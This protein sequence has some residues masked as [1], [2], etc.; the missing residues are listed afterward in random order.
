MFDKRLMVFLAASVGGG[1]AIGFFTLPGEWYARLE[2]P[3]F[4][5]PNWIFGP[6]WT[7]LYIM[8]G[9]AGWRLWRLGETTSRAALAFVPVQIWIAQLALNFLWSPTFFRAHRID[10]ALIVIACLWMT[11]LAFILRARKYDKWAALLFS[12][13]LAWVSFAMVLNAA[14]LVLNGAAP[15]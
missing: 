3:S 6:V 9:V 10:L 5:P 13:Y 15:L 2:K 8:I 1:L 11:I 7:V 4:N 14:L 12:P